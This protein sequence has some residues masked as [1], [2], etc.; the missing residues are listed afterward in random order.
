MY[1]YLRGQIIEKGPTRIVLDV[2]GVGF[3]ITVPLSTAEKLPR[4]G[5][6]KILTHLHVREDIHKLFGFAT[7]G[8][9]EMFLLL[10]KVSGIGP[11]LAVA[12]LS[13]ATVI[14]LCHAIG[15]GRIDF[16]KSLKG[17]GPKTATRLVTELGDK[18]QL[19]AAGPGLRDLNPV[20]RYSEDAIQAL[21]VLGCPP[22][23]ARSA[24]AQVQEE[25][26]DIEVEALVR[27]SLR[28]IWPS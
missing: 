11:T 5:E 16:L 18:I 28:I 27:A 8:E 13:R 19:L 3:E 26:P 23:A 24:V 17:V 20:D 21:E 9:R 4:S 15:E 22:K 7:K 6:A 10:K 12:I 1:D 25:K 2:D 14:D